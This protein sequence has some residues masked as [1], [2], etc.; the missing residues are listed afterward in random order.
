MRQA[1]GLQRRF[2][3]DEPRAL[4]WAGIMQAYGLILVPLLG[5]EACQTLVVLDWNFRAAASESDHWEV[6]ESALSPCA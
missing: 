4:P 5:S 6:L 2:R 1:F 3:G